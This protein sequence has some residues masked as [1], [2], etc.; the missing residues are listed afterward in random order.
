MPIY[1]DKCDMYKHNWS[2]SSLSRIYHFTLSMN[3]I[4][5][6]QVQSYMGTPGNFDLKLLLWI[7]WCVSSLYTEVL[8]Q[9]RQHAASS[10][11]VASFKHVTLGC[12]I[13]LPSPFVYYCCHFNLM[14]C[15][16]FKSLV[17]A[18]ESTTVI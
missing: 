9:S 10:K 12:I 4:M 17:T 5:R 16:L 18:Q 1:L 11:Y 6:D 13:V 8:E 3:V 15:W 14:N 7:G 2:F